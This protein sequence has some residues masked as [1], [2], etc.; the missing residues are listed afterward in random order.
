MAS[1][2]YKTS[3][4]GIGDR[5]FAD[6]NSGVPLPICC[7]HIKFSCRNAQASLCL[8][9]DRYKHLVESSLVFPPQLPLRGVDI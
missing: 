2:V 8:K 9:W 7:R 4:L 6:Q 3:V 1:H 5:G